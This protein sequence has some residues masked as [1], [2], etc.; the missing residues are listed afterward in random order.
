MTRRRPIVQLTL[1][2]DARK[3]LDE[4]ATRC[5]E[6]RSGM[7]ERLV[8]EAE[9]PQGRYAPEV[10]S[11]SRERAPARHAAL[12]DACVP[13]LHAICRDT[14]AQRPE[15]G[16]VSRT[17]SG[18]RGGRDYRLNWKAEPDGVY[19][20]GDYAIRHNAPGTS[21]PWTVYFK[22]EPLQ[23]A[24][25]DFTGYRRFASAENAQR[26]VERRMRGKV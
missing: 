2:D 21:K 19:R 22:G 10:R 24:H 17:G 7:V 15:G 26:W 18:K 23:R 3:R 25:G 6:T 4:I 16:E 9:M 14:G 1:S 13:G 5:G 11:W 8:R 12:R 20:F